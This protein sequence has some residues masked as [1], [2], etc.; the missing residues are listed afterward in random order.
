MWKVKKFTTP[1]TGHR[2]RD[3]MVIGFTTTY[4]I[5]A[6]HHNSCEFD[7]ARG[8]VYSIQHHVI[9]FV[10]DFQMVGGF[11]WALVSSTNKTDHHDITEILL[12]LALNSINQPNQTTKQTFSD[13]LCDHVC[14]LLN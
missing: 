5:S 8:E 9:K 7:S 6:Y 13:D 2:G 3:H 11:L 14:H 10:S 12:N 4:V 1:K